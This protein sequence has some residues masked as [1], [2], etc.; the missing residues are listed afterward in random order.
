MPSYPIFYHS[1]QDRWRR[2]RLAALSVVALIGIAFVV[3]GVSLV[4]RPQLSPL[5]IDM[6]GMRSKQMSPLDPPPVSPAVLAASRARTTNSFDARAFAAQSPQQ[7][8]NAAASQSSKMIAFHVNWDEKSLT[9]LKR[10]IGSIDMLIPEWLHLSGSG[11]GVSLDNPDRMNEALQFIRSEKPDLTI[12]PLINNYNSQTQ[13]WDVDLLKKAIGTEASR[14]ALIRSL[15]DFNKKYSLSGVS[16]DFEGVPKSEQANVEL[17]MRQLYAQFHKEGMRVSQSIP[18]VDDAFDPAKLGKSADFL[19]LIATDEYVASVSGAGPVASQNWFAQS[20]AKRF[21]EFPSENYVIAMGGYGYDW[22]ENSKE[23]KQ[24]TFD[25]AMRNAQNSQATITLDEP[26]LNPTYSYTDAEN[27]AHRVW[28]LDAITAFNQIRAARQLGNPYGYALWRLGAEDPSLWDVVPKRDSLDAT[29]ALSLEQMRSGYG[30]T[31]QGDGK[32]LSLS[33]GPE[34]GRRRID[35]DAPSGFITGESIVNFPST[36]VIDRLGGVGDKK[37]IV[38]TFDDGP[39]N[40]YTPQMLDILKQYDVPATFFLVGVNAAAHRDIVQRIMD[41]GHEIGNHTYTHPNSGTISPEQFRFEI[42]ATER[43]LESILGRQFLLFR[44]PYME[45]TEPTTPDEMASLAVAS[46]LGYYTTGINVD[47][48]DWKRPGTDVIAQ[49]VIRETAA[50]AGSIIL[51]HDS[52]GDRSQTV[53][54]LPK[55]IETLQAEGYRFVSMSDFL[56]VSKD[57]LMPRIT[58]QDERFSY[59]NKIA[60]FSWFGFSRFLTY[61]LIIGISLGITR[62]LFM[63]ILAVTQFFSARRKLKALEGVKFEPQVAVIIPAFNEEKVIVQTVSSILLS[64]YRRLR[65]IVVDDGSTD[66]TVK[67][68]HAVFKTHPRVQIF[69]KKNGGKSSAL[70]FGIEQTAKRDEILVMLDSDTVFRAD[71]IEKLVRRFALGN[72]AAVAGNAKVGNRLN[73]LTK[74]QALEYITGQNLDRRAFEVVNCISVV[75]GSAGAWRRDAVIE[76][77][78][79]SEDTLAEDADLT[80]SILRRGHRIVYADDAHAFTEA[81]DTVM[82]F[83]N[84]RFRWMFGTMQVAWKHK[85]TLFRRR[86]GTVGFFAIPNIFIFQIFFSLIAPFMDIAFASSLIWALWQKY[87]HPIGYDIAQTLHGTITYYLI[88]LALDMATS[89]IPFFLERKEQWRLLLYL[90]LQRFFYRQLMYYVAIKSVSA[91][92]KGR[93]VKWGNIERKATS[94]EVKIAGT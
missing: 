36:Y 20:I 66:R 31:Y 21:K 79:F 72:I 89:V 54:A 14:Q 59:A 26:S 33:K 87:Q 63:A 77:G 11:D 40:E 39:D 42:D 65:V 44:A 69:T 83:I 17:F 70:N 57:T 68:L 73:I 24:V 22:I 34:T 50:G 5:G 92:I 52:G 90:P 94:S 27:V 41:D 76:A 74:W 93:F 47:T 25:E 82:S 64:T 75:P 12:M 37:K 61:S 4:I 80:L 84:Q 28:F 9:S 86:F 58:A 30:V 62:F 16:I 85:D 6:P 38:L 18:L 2:G 3:F 7:R 88:F 67:F 15:L 56:N 60:F 8:S 10:N 51:L 91:A 32:I 1:R 45:D 78:G 53:E 55:I 29:T 35:Y 81:P 23:G 49:T 13:K 48:S 71:T 46:N 43:V 19:I